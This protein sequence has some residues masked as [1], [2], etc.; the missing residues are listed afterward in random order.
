[1]HPTWEVIW[2]F[3]LHGFCTVI[4]VVVKKAVIDKWQL[5]WAVSG[6]VTIGFV[7]VTSRWLFFPQ[8]NKEWCGYKGHRGV[9]HFD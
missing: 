1:M 3:V 2:F 7:A 5:H 6:P 9:L 4:E 8:I